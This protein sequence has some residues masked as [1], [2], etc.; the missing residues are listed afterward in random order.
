M[1]VLRASAEEFGKMESKQKLPKPKLTP[2]I[3]KLGM[4]I[5]E[6]R[7][8]RYPQEVRN[9]RS[10]WKERKKVCMFVCLCVCVRE[11]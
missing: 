7:I 8:K 1:H 6:E 9:K 3:A 11:G 4:Q 10:D 2:T 5:L